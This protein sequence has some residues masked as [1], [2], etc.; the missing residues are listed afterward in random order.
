MSRVIL[1]YT[2]FGIIIQDDNSHGTA[3][4]SIAA[5]N[6]VGVS[7]NATLI[8]VK[9]MDSKGEGNVAD[10]LDAVQWIIRDAKNRRITNG[11]AVVKYNSLIQFIFCLL[12]LSNMRFLDLQFVVWDTEEQD[13]R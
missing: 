11:R 1:G 10:L 12:R 7:K 3:V 9:I 13:D 2:A 5:G 6:T 4:A 8:S